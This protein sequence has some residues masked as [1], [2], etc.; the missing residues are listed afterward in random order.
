MSLS[1]RF[2][3]KHIIISLSVL[4]FNEFKLG[5]EIGEEL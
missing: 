3:V 5:V 2:V 1:S 4:I